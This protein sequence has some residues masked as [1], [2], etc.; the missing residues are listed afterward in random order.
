[1]GQFNGGFL[2]IS[3]DILDEIRAIFRAKWEQRDGKVVP[4]VENVGLG[5]DAVILSGTVLYADMADSTTL[6]S[7]FKNWF[8]AEMYKAYL[9]GACRIINDLNGDIT[10]FDGDRVMAV[11]T[12]D[13]KNTR[14]VKTALKI[15]FLVNQIN[16]TIKKEYPQTSYSLSQKIG[17]DTSNLFVAKTG[18]RKY[19]D[20]VW[21]GKA[22]NYA[23]KLCEIGDT[24]Y[25]THITE[26]VYLKISTEAKYGG[27]SR[28]NMWEKRI[29]N[30]M[31]TVIYRSNWW[32]EF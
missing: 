8:A 26:D 11:Y 6:V 10:A 28:Q 29:W 2:M 15:N 4:D 19:N 16:Q 7:N 1:M 22:A 14:A 13:T 24:I 23:A 30:T 18:I 31:G 17:I 3:N 27:D 21:V 5:N 12:G 20:L 25:P 32:W 9:V